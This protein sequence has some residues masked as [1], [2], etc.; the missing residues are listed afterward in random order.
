MK[1]TFSEAIK[2]KD[3]KLYNLPYHQARIERTQAKFSGERII[4]SDV[5]SFIPRHVQR[6]LFKCRVVYG[7]Q[8]EKIEFIPYFY[9]QIETISI[10]ID[11][12]IDYCFKYTDRTRLDELLKQSACDDIIIVKQGLITDGFSS[13]LVFE[14]K[15]GLFTPDTCLLQGTKRQYLLDTKKI[16]EKRIIL[17]DINAYS[18]IHFINAMIDLEDGVCMDMARLRSLY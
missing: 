18:H 11:N 1:E 3:G 4:L 5:L 9:R 14:S 12:D 2:L 6:G 13:N 8:V 7:S 17:D 16:K 15:E 10:V